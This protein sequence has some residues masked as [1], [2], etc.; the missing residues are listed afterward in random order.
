MAV[1]PPQQATLAGFLIG[2]IGAAYAV[3]G[4]S[5][6]RPKPHDR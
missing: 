1:L 6:T 4:A 3:V 5:G 2:Q